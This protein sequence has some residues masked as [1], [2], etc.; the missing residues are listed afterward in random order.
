MFSK[1]E[2][3][4][5]FDPEHPGKQ[6]CLFQTLV[7]DFLAALWNV[8]AINTRGLCVAKTSRRQ[9]ICIRKAD[10]MKFCN[11]AS[12]PCFRMHLLNCVTLDL[13]K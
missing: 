4:T 6:K 10:T 1:S 12:S 13:L 8:K 9:E 7:Y 3:R 11:E 2:K 5:A